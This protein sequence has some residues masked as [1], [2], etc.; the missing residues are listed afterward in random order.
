MNSMK[1]KI[2]ILEPDNFSEYAI[3]MLEKTFQVEKYTDGDLKEF[4]QDKY[5]IFVRLKYYINDEFICKAH[6]LQYICSPTTG[7]NHI[8]ISRPVEVLSLK[9]EDAFLETIRA[10]PEHTFGLSIALLRNYKMA[11]LDKSN[12]A[13]NRDLYRGEEIYQNTVGIIGM[14][15]VGRILAKY[16]KAFQAKVF[17]YDINCEK[18]CIGAVRTDSVEELIKLSSIIH[19][20]ASYSDEYKA[21]FGKKYFDLMK[22]K[23]FINTSRGEL[24][25]EQSLLKYIQKGEYKGI[26]I[27][28]VS[29]ETEGNNNIVK[30]IS[31]SE[32]KNIII[33]PHIS[34][35]TFSSMHRT[36]EFITSKMLDRLKR[37]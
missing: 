5:A 2:G 19:L 14:G 32:G 29:K 11:F 18:E 36:E 23:Y 13:W 15:R 1:K 8:N 33:T 12:S 24:V 4:V 22:N 3:K 27:D 16:Y 9:G 34:G 17:Y 37:G 7:L 30:L 20:C 21:F 10:T 25:D 31:L 26:A 35:A 28:V 6:D